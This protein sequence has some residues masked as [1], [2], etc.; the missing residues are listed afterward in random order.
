M[1]FSLLLLLPGCF[2][3]VGFG[4]FVCFNHRNRL[5]HKETRILYMKPSS[6]QMKIWAW[7]G[8]WIR[9]QIKLPLPA[10]SMDFNRSSSL[11]LHF[12]TWRTGS[13]RFTSRYHQNCLTDV[14]HAAQL[15]TP[16]AAFLFFFF[17]VFCS[18]SW[19]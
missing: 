5:R 3:I 16:C 15:S 7:E 13:I 8:W 6:L 4:S 10:S 12:R 2:A 9:V 1:S 18:W 19:S 17:F 14:R 11:R